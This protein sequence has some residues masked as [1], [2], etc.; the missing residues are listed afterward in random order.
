MKCELPENINQLPEFAQEEIRA[1]WYVLLYTYLN[2]QLLLYCEFRRNYVP[3]DDCKQELIITDDILAVLDML[4]KD[5]ERPKHDGSTPLD[6]KPTYLTTIFPTKHETLI[7]TRSVVET[8]LTINNTFPSL[9]STTAS[10]LLPP[11]IRASDPTTSIVP[12]ATEEED[13]DYSDFVSLSLILFIFICLFT[14]LDNN[15]K[16]HGS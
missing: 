16:A 14:C 6:L 11:I 9:E 7:T 2:T 5:L 4:D 8:G 12:T 15:F 3:G 13:I 10:I 1:V